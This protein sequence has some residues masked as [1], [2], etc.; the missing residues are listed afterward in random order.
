LGTPSNHC[1][2]LSGREVAIALL[3]ARGLRNRE[4]AIKLGFTVNQ[5]AISLHNIYR[6][7]GICRGCRASRTKLILRLTRAVRV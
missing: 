7:T 4:I 1:I 3:V 2:I 6:K 5:V